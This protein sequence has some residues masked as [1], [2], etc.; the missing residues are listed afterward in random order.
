MTKA[1]D[2]A[3]VIR[4]EKIALVVAQFNVEICESLL[5]G[6]IAALE[7]LGYTTDKLSVYR[8]PGAFEIPVVA[9]KCA[10]SGDFAGVICLGCVIR[11]GTPH[12]EYV[13]EAVTMG[14]TQIPLETGVPVG[15]GILTTDNQA[16]AE[17]R[18]SDDEFNKGRECAY[19]VSETIDVL[20]S[21]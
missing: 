6:A 4:E 19:A 14:L 21:I 12:F 20:Q 3:P 16:Q 7:E 10:Q 18:A 8:V 9:Q 1:K 13:C 5:K 17:E 2:G 11:G 15:F